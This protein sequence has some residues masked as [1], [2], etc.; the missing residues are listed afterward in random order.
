MHVFKAQEDKCIPQV[1]E[2]IKTE[3]S[4]E[5]KPTYQARTHTAARYNPYGLETPNTPR[6]LPRPAYENRRAG[7]A[8]DRLSY[9]ADENKAEIVAKLMRYGGQ[10]SS[11][12]FLFV[13]CME[14]RIGSGFKISNYIKEQLTPAQMEEARNDEDSCVRIINAKLDHEA[15]FRH[16]RAFVP[17]RTFP[18]LNPQRQTGQRNG[19]SLTAPVE[20]LSHRAARFVTTES[21]RLHLGALARPL[22]QFIREAP[23]KMWEAELAH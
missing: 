7:F 14:S 20:A 18:P 9:I 12:W 13:I 5:G 21:H 6:R 22:Q 4:L 15:R 8:G 3:A 17:V 10:T 2:E 23:K 11:S 19:F 1:N 16:T